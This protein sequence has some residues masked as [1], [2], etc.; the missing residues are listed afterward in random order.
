MKKNHGFA[1]LASAVVLFAGAF[2]IGMGGLT[3]AL[4][5]YRGTGF[6]NATNTVG[7]VLLLLGGVTFVWTFLR[8]HRQGD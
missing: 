2:S 1:L 4:S 6:E 7:F 5:K 3:M 8:H